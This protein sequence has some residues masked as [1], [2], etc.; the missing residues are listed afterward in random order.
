MGEIALHTLMLMLTELTNMFLH[1]N[2]PRIH[3]F[4][5]YIPTWFCAKAKKG[6]SNWGNRAHTYQLQHTVVTC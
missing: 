3:P 4:Y 1:N 6:G 2:R 5:T